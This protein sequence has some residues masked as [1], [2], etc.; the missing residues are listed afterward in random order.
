MSGLCIT[1]LTAVSKITNS[2]RSSFVHEF[3]HSGIGT[4]KN[5]FFSIRCCSNGR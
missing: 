1:V 4:G 3:V 2:S 5:T